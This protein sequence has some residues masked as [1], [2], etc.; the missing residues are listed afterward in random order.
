MNFNNIVQALEFAYTHHK[1][2]ASDIECGIHLLRRIEHGIVKHKTT[3]DTLLVAA[4]RMLTHIAEV[5]QQE[6]VASEDEDEDGDDSGDA[7]TP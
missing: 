6:A 7:P 4:D 1:E 5:Q 3:A 2:L